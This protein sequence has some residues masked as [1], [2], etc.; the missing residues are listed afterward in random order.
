MCYIVALVWSYTD[1]ALCRRFYLIILI[2]SR[3][4][5]WMSYRHTQQMALNMLLKQCSQPGGAMGHPTGHQMAQLM[6]HS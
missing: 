4:R 2:Y 1:R 5:K 3:S 6:T